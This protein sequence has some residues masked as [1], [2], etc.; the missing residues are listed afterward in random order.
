LKEE[1]EKEI[2]KERM[3]IIVKVKEKR[4]KRLR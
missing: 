3:L 1:T 2:M 4:S